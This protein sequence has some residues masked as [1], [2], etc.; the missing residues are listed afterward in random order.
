MENVKVVRDAT[1]RQVLEATRVFCF[2]DMSVG[3]D[4][5]VSFMPC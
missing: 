1:E 5:G 3:L 2:P 4:V